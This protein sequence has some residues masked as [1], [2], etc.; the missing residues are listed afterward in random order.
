MR[1]IFYKD[2]YVTDVYVT[3]VQSPGH[4]PF[5]VFQTPSRMTSE[6]CQ[7]RARSDGLVKLLYRIRV[8]HKN[9][10]PIIGKKRATV[11]PKA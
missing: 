7:A 11:A 9:Q 6:L 5:F 3:A 4:K 10:F 8:K 1:P 2:K